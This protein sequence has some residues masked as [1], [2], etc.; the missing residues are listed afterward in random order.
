MM[1]KSISDTTAAVRRAVYCMVAALCGCATP[2]PSAEKPTLPPPVAVPAPPAT[3]PAPAPAK[4]A[5]TVRPVPEMPTPSLAR[6]A[7]WSALPGWN[8]EN[9]TLVWKALLAS[10]GAMKER[11]EWRTPCAVAAQSPTPDA[12]YVR[13]YFET[14]FTPYQLT[15]PDGSDTGLV[16]GYYEP[17]LHGSRMPFSSG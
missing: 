7:T 11:L 2:P 8:E 16:T 14:H 10:C 5:E 1:R 4:P 12:A 13:R 9:H 3:P 17:L 6:P 15:N